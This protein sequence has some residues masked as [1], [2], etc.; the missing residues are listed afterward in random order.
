M[1]SQQLKK[2]GGV[3]ILVKFGVEYNFSKPQG[4]LLQFTLRKNKISF[5]GTIITDNTLTFSPITWTNS[6]ASNLSETLDDSNYASESSPSRWS[7]LKPAEKI[8]SSED[9]NEAA[10]AFHG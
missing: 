2:W 6:E 3:L 7:V 5:C 9:G 4:G 10:E 8:C 1:N